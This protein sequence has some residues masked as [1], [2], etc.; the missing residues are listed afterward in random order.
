MVAELKE[1]QSPIHS[2]QLELTMKERSIAAVKTEL[3]AENRHLRS[4]SD[5]KMREKRLLV[6]DVTQLKKLADVATQDL[7]HKEGEHKS[8]L[9][10]LHATIHSAKE[11]ERD[12]RLLQSQLQEQI[13]QNEAVEAQLAEKR[14]EC[15]MM[16]AAVRQLEEQ[17]TTTAQSVQERIALQ[18]RKEAEKLRTQLREKQLAADEDKYLQSK[19]AEDCGR[20]TKE[21]ARLQARM[22]ETTKQLEE[23]RSLRDTE[24]LSRTRRISELVSG[25]ENER[26]LELQL[27][28]WRRLAQDEKE[29][30]SAAEQ[31]V[32]QLQQGRKSVEM[33]GSS[34]HKQLTDLQNKQSSLQ[35]EN[36]LLR[37]E[38]SHLVEH[39]SQLHK[40]TVNQRGLQEPCL[41]K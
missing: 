38:K 9:Q 8:I 4:V 31:Q 2:M 29:K 16:Q 19:L 41:E 7:A 26:Q 17:Y 40:Q 1:L 20:L 35:Q 30:V 11:K 32:L 21:N 13:Q 14:S 36:S 28:H 27:S 39:I 25:K 3:E 33:S 18:L 6:E 12:L 34:L 24:S 22:L 23:E 37:V 15:L 10:E 5:N